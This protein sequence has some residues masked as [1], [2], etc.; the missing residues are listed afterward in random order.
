MKRETRLPHPR[1]D[2]G[3]HLPNVAEVKLGGRRH[4]RRPRPALG[5]ERA[6]DKHL[7]CRRIT[8]RYFGVNQLARSRV[9]R[10]RKPLADANDLALGKEN[11]P[12]LAVVIRLAQ[13]HIDAHPCVERTGHERHRRT[14]FACR[15]RTQR[16]DL[17]GRSVPLPIKSDL[18]AANVVIRGRQG[19]G[20]LA[21]RRTCG[22]DGKARR[23]RA[24]RL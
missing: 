14:P 7:S 1:I 19:R 18:R 11:R 5:I 8:R 24:D 21:G 22:V 12:V 3:A 6:I 23:E 15:W 10:R 9:I 13:Q 20:N 16:D 17:H 4:A 2:V